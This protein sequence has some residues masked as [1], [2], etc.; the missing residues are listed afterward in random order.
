[1]LSNILISVP[2]C[3]IVLV[4]GR[5]DVKVLLVFEKLVDNLKYQEIKKCLLVLMYY[6]SP[7]IITSS[8]FVANTPNCELLYK[9]AGSRPVMLLKQTQIVNK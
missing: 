1:M 7:W 6:P 3:D 4:N 8:P 9:F 2:T 5:G